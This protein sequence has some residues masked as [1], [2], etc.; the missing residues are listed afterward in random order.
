MTATLSLMLIGLLAAF[1]V[2]RKLQ[3]A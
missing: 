1:F 3:I 2:R